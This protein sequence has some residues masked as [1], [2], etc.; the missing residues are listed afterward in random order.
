LAQAPSLRVVDADGA[1]LLTKREEDLLRLVAEGLGK[2]EIARQLN[3]SENTVKNYMFRIFDKLG[4]SNRVELVLYALS[5]AKR[6]PVP[7]PAD[8]P[9]ALWPEPEET[10]P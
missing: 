9:P 5:S 1:N 2:R 6:A 10:E 7:I 3:L 4:I 8:N